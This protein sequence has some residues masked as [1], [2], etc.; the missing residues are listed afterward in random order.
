V[1]ERWMPRGRRLRGAGYA[2]A[3]VLPEALARRQPDRGLESLAAS[4]EGR[5]LYTMME[6]SLSAAPPGEGPRPVRI[7]QV[8]TLL[9]RTVSQWAYLPEPPP[10]GALPLR[11]RITALSFVNSGTLLAVEE[12]PAGARLYSLDVGAATSV[13]GGAHDSPSGSTFDDLDAAGLANAGIVPVSKSLV[14]D[15]GRVA[16]PGSRIEGLAILDGDTISINTDDGFGLAAPRTLLGL[17]A[18]LEAPA[19]RPASRLLTI[20]LEG[21]LPL[22]R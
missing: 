15:L 3:E 14:L 2:Q 17:D 6:G 21:A 7:L 13:L 10:D 19:G 4:G 1:L 9:A 20:R 16:G 12:T 8:D 22:G 11:S 18:P 5:F